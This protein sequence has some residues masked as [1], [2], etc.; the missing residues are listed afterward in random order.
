MAT[1]NAVKELW[2][3]GVVTE[4]YKG[5]ALSEN[6]LFGDRALELE[7]VTAFVVQKLDSGYCSH[8]DFGCAH[9]SLPPV[10]M[11]RMADPQPFVRGGW[12]AGSCTMPGPACSDAEIRLFMEG[13]NVLAQSKQR[14]RWIQVGGSETVATDDDTYTL[15]VTKAPTDTRLKL[16]AGAPSSM[17]EVLRAAMPSLEV[18]ASITGTTPAAPQGT[19]PVAPQA[20]SNE[21]VAL[22]SSRGSFL[23]NGKRLWTRLQLLG[24]IVAVAVVGA[25][26]FCCAFCLGH[27]FARDVTL[28]KCEEPSNLDPIGIE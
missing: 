25:A 21:V 12:S 28:L 4:L 23:G 22:A 14:Q 3:R 7:S 8:R 26:L 10:Y 16:G 24:T 11:L 15:E 17:A 2:T 20:G 6:R 19:T 13:Q 9:S 5:S 18:G 1:V 27:T